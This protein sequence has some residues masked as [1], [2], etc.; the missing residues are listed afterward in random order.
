MEKSQKRQWVEESGESRDIFAGTLWI[1]S[2][3][4]CVFEIDRKWLL[5]YNTI[6][7]FKG[8]QTFGIHEEVQ[9]M[10]KVILFSMIV[11]LVVP[12]L[13]QGG[14]DRTVIAEL[15]TGTW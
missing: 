3:T 15:A 5:C 10:K 4:G 2:R 1:L 6:V 11:S 12:A 14:T 9:T 13:V 7:D 8:N